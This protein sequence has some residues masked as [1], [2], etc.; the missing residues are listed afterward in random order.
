MYLSHALDRTGIDFVVL[1]Q[2]SVVHKQSAGQVLSPQ[3][4]RLLTLKSLKAPYVE[5]KRYTDE[6]TVKIFADIQII[7]STRFRDTEARMIVTHGKFWI[8][9]FTWDTWRSWFLDRYVLP[10]QGVKAVEKDLWDNV[11]I[12]LISR[13]IVLEYVPFESKQGRVSWNERIRPRL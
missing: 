13:G 2:L 10:W 1:Q 9:H 5:K 6:E 3:S 11:S 4:T 7:P 12:P 8:R